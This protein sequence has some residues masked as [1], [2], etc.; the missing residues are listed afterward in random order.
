MAK[1]RPTGSKNADVKVVVVQV[2]ACPRC[3]STKRA[4]YYNRRSLKTAGQI[5]VWRRTKCLECGQV[6]DDKHSESEENN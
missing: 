4:P 3:N 2:T 5:V 1:G 6:R